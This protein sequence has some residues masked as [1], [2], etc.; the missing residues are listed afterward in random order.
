MTSRA[1]YL[2][3]GISL[4]ILTWIKQHQNRREQLFPLVTIEHSYRVRALRQPL[5]TSPS[6]QFQ[7]GLLWRLHFQ[8]VF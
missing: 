3:R 2:S 8:F 4:I 6:C 7:E 1:S 5:R